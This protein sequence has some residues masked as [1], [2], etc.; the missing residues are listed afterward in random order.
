MKTSFMFYLDDATVTVPQTV[1]WNLWYNPGTINK[2]S[3]S[4]FDSMAWNLVTAV[5][6]G[7]FMCTGGV[8]CNLFT[9]FVLKGATCFI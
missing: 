2:Y 3:I 8:L 6:N 5:L 4:N 1:S 7:W 9:S